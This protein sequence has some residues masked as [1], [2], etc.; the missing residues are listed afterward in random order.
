MNFI[1]CRTKPRS[2]WFDPERRKYNALSLNI[3]MLFERE[4]SPCWNQ[5][6]SFFFYS[7]SVFL[8]GPWLSFIV[9]LFS[10]PE[11]L[12]ASSPLFFNEILK[13]FPHS[14]RN[15]IES[16]FLESSHLLYNLSCFTAILLGEHLIAFLV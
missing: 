9:F 6:G 12:N 5:M 2:S 13:I 7:I 3:S 15:M 10:F 1:C 4:S 16:L 14:L 8:F 11:F